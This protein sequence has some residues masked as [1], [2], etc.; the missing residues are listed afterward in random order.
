MGIDAKD[1]KKGGFNPEDSKP[2][3]E[4]KQS[5]SAI[6]TVD[7]NP[8]INAIKIA[9]AAEPF[10]KYKMLDEVATNGWHLPSSEL[11]AI[12]DRKSLSGQEFELYGYK[13][14]RMGKAGSESTWKVEKL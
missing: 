10:G 3:K 4:T 5:D 6:A 2:Q 14:T 13:F 12:L 11:G 1:M 8:T 9:A 7:E